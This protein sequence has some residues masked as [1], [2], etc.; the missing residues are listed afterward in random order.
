MI[1]APR[2]RGRVSDARTR[3]WALGAAGR[4]ARAAAL[5]AGPGFPDARPRG[6]TLPPLGSVPTA[7]A[8]TG[9]SVARDRLHALN[10][11]TP[12]A[13]RAKA[14]RAGSAL[15]AWLPASVSSRLVSSVL[16]RKLSAIAG[17]ATN[18]D[19]EERWVHA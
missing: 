18:S 17:P 11:G 5:Q 14:G 7:R 16:T 13:G 19:R 10:S 1:H 8:S 3:Q 15:T 4:G 12:R 2:A 9:P 6:P